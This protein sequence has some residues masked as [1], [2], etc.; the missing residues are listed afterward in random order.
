MRSPYKDEVEKKMEL[1]IYQGDHLDPDWLETV[2]R[3]ACGG[4][5]EPAVHVTVC[6]TRSQLAEAISCAARLERGDTERYFPF[7]T[8]ESTHLLP[9]TDILYFESRDHRVRA[10]LSDGAALDSPTLRIAV[11]DY[12]EHLI[13][14]RKFM[15]ISKSVFVNVGRVRAISARRL[16]LDNGMELP[17]SRNYYP[18]AVTLLEALH[19][20]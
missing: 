18:D 8:R 20:N 17:V 15:R 16:Y 4:Q 2:R 14:A 7:R 5:A 3:Q 6:R 19:L 11:S 13:K 10:H 9:H 1:V 12:L